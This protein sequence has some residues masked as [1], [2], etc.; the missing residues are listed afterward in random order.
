MLCA[1]IHQLYKYPETIEFA[2]IYQN[3]W[4]KYL[5]CVVFTSGFAFNQIGWN[6]NLQHLY[7]FDIQH[8]HT[9]NNVKE[10]FVWSFLQNYHIEVES[11]SILM[12]SAYQNTSC[13]SC[14]AASIGPWLSTWFQNMTY[15]IRIPIT[16]S[17]VNTNQS[18]INSFSI[19]MKTVTKH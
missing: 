10:W 14:R 2:L 15:S 9:K 11:H 8:L 19:I 18:Q 13:T 3:N 7:R 5:L 16:V 4:V 6:E 12:L 17:H 1:R